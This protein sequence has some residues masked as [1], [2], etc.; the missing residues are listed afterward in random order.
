MTALTDMTEYA[1][2]AN[3]TCQGAWIAD[4]EHEAIQMCA[5]DVGTEGNTKGMHAYPVADIS[6]DWLQV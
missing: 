5:D 4:D 1:V 6:A 3:D 2:F